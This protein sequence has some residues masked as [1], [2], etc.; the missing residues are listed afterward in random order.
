MER[1]LSERVVT[2]IAATVQE[3]RLGRF[4]FSSADIARVY[5]WAVRHDRPVYWAC[6]RLNWPPDCCPTRLPTPATMSRRLRR[7]ELRERMDTLIARLRQRSRRKLVYYV[8]GKPLALRDHTRDSDAKKG[9]ASGGY[10]KGYKLHLLGGS[11]AK[12]EFSW[13]PRVATVPV[14][15]WDIGVTTRVVYAVSTCSSNHTPALDR[16]CTA[17]VP[18]STPSPMMQDPLRGRGVIGSRPTNGTRE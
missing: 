10:A 3:A 2:L 6:Q 16:R 12:V 14:A 17:S 4:T 15:A 11:V 9:W 1:Q 8:D 13:W 18:T 7:V 5:F